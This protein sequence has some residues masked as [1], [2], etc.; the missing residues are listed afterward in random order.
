MSRKS[1]AM[2]LGFDVTA[3]LLFAVLLTVEIWNLSPVFAGPM[4]QQ[5]LAAL[6]DPITQWLILAA[7]AGY[8]MMFCILEHRLSPPGKWWR[9]GN[10]DLWLS[11]LFL[12][13]LLRYPFSNQKGIGFSYVSTILAGIVFGNAVCTLVCWRSA[14]VARSTA[15]FGGLLN[16]L[17]AGAALWQPATGRMRIQYHD[18]A[19]WSGIWRN[20]NHYG[21]MMGAGLVLATGIGA[22]AWRVIIGKRRKMLCVILCSAAAVLCGCGVFKSY[23][24]GTWLGVLAGLVYLA[25][26]TGKYSRPFAWL[27]RNRLPMALLVASLPLLAFWQFRFSEWPPAQR[28]FSVVNINDF[29]WRNRVAAWE[30]AARSMVER[31]LAGFGWVRV[32]PINWP[33]YSPPQPG[34]GLAISTNDYL[35]LGTS[36][37]VPALLCFAAYLALSFRAKST[38]PRAPLSVFTICRA[39]SMVFLIGFW[40]DGGLFFLGV[41][42]VF[43][44]LLELSRLEPVEAPADSA[45]SEA[46][47]EPG[48]VGAVSRSKGEIWLRRTSLALAA[49]ALL[50]STVYVGTPFFPANRLT[51]AIARKCLIPPIERNDLDYLASNPIWTGRK[52]RALLEHVDLANY[53][54]RLVNW[55]LDDLLYREYVLTPAIQPERD[56]LLRWRRPLWEFFYPGIRKQSHDR[57]AAKF[58]LQQLKHDVAVSSNAPPTIDEMWRQ[59]MADAEGFE[60]LCVAAFRAV[61]IPARLGGD[62]RAEF[63]DGKTWQPVSSLVT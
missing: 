25:V 48:L 35:V 26:Q 58:V 45:S 24:R 5:V 36:A 9:L 12:L 3:F 39:S 46:E 14:Q 17:L 30:D 21:L 37:G 42:M 61:G 56:G 54:R 59:K 8:F 47:N 1:T 60:A 27:R 31:P 44:T 10:A 7:L 19:R 16:C 29:S 32:Q 63:F 43:W 62:E 15:W 28:V 6:R 51:L 34:A 50:Q 53:N 11:A 40:L 2:T 41:T 57:D 20:P 55:T 13:A 23:S 33:N 4:R 49:I 22:M 18:V 52:L 38:V